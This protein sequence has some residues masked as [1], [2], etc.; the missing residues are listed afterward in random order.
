MLDNALFTLLISIIEA[1]EPGVGI[2]NIKGKPG[3][4][5]QQSFQPTQEGVPTGPAAF[6]HIIGYQRVGSPYRADIWNPD[7]GVEV[8]TEIQQMATTFQLSGLS[9][10]DP[11]LPNQY[12]AGDI[13]TLLSAVMQ[14]DSTLKVLRD[15]SA[16]EVG[17]QRVLEIRNPY[18]KD[19]RDRNEA[20]PS[21]DFIITHK[22]IVT[23]EVPVLES[24][25][26][27]IYDV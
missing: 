20:N 27:A 24:T 1:A 17:I 22:L 4:P 6:L 8:H 5:V 14:S 23:S 21:F 3:V 13:V 12:T 7:L 2:P 9:T 25:E 16:G 10:Q 15:G 19:D 26:L 11:N 18:F